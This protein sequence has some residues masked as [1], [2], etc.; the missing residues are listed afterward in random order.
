MKINV[1]YISCLFDES[2]WIQFQ[3]HN[4]TVKSILISLF[5]QY[6]QIRK[7][8]LNIMIRVN[9]K[10][11]HPS[12]WRNKL[13]DGDEVLI[14]QEVGEIGFL[15]V[16]LTAVGFS[17][18]TAA[19]ISTV[20]GVVLTVVS[21][22]YTIYSYCT[23][24]KPSHSG[25]AGLNNSPT[26]GWDGLQMQV[27]QG[28]PVPIVY[29]EH[30]VGGN[31]IDCYISS[32]SDKNYLNM[33]IAL[34]EG[35]IEGIMKEDLSGTCSVLPRSAEGLIT[36]TGIPVADDN[37]TIGGRVLTWMGGTY[38]P[39]GTIFV[40][41]TTLECVMNAID[42]INRDIGNLVVADKWTGNA[43]R[44]TAV[45]PGVAGNTIT[46]TESSA[47]TSMSGSGFLAGGINGDM[48]YVLIN[49]NLLSNYRSV[50]YD[51][52]TGTQ[53]Q[54]AIAGFGNVHQTYSTSGVL[55]GFVPYTYT[56]VDSDVEAIEVRVRV[57]AMYVQYRGDYY[58]RTL[59]FIVEHKLTSSGTWIVDGK[60]TITNS[61]LSPIRRYYKIDNLTAGRY[62][63]RLTEYQWDG[64]VTNDSTIVGRIYL[65]NVIE[66]KRDSLAYPH[67][68]LLALKIM[69]T[70]QLSGG[71]PNVL[72]RIRGIKVY[73]LSTTATAWTKNP[74][75]NI[76]NLMVNTRYGV[77]NYITQSN[78]NV[79]QFILMAAYC[80]TVVDAESRFELDIVIDSFNPAFDT[81]NQICGSFRATP[82][83]NK[84]AIQLLIDKAETPSYIFNM[85]SIIEGS[86][87]HTFTSEKS[88]ANSIIVDFAD[89]AKR[90]QKETVEITDSAVITGGTPRRTRNM[91][92]IGASRQSQVY[93]EARYHL[94]AVKYQDEQI[95]FR[96]A[97]D[98]IHVLPGDVVK[99]QHDTFEW[100]IGGRVVTATAVSITVDQSITIVGGHTYTLTCKLSNDTLESK[101]LTNAAGVHTVL[102]VAGPGFTSAPPAFGIYVVGETG[103]DVKT[104]RIMSL[105]KTPN[106]EIEVT[107]TEYSASVYSD[108]AI[109]VATPY[110][111]PSVDNPPPPDIIPGLMV[112]PECTG[113][114][115][116][117]ATDAM[118]I[119]ISFTIPSSLTNWSYGE[120]QVSSNLGVTY[121]T[122]TTFNQQK[123]YT[124]RDV[125][126]GATYWVKIL[127]F[128]N[129]G[130]VGTSPPTSSIVIAGSV[131]TPAVPTGLALT[132]GISK[133]A[134]ATDYSWVY[135]NWNDNVETNF[136][137]YEYRIKETGGYYT[138]GFV[139]SSDILFT[140]IRS[141]ILYYVGV[142]A[143]N[144]Y[145]TSSAFCT[146]V[147]VTSA[148]DTTAPAVPTALAASSTFK[149]IVLTWTNPADS[150]LDYINIY[151]GT[152]AVRGGATLVAQVNGTSYVDN[153]GSYGLTRYYWISAVDTSGNISTETG[154]V[155]ATTAMIATS[156]IDSFAID[157]SKIFTK[158]PIITG[159]SWTN[160]SPVAGSI[161]WGAHTLIYN[162]VSYTIAANNTS[163][164]YIYWIYGN[165]FYTSSNTHPAAI[166]TDNDFIIAVNNSGVHDLAWNSIANEVIGSV[167]IQNAAIKTALI[168]DLQV[169]TIKIANNAVSNRGEAR[170]S[171]E[172]N[173][174]S[175]TYVD[176]L[177]L[178]L[179]TNGGSV[180]ISARTKVL[181]AQN[182]T[183]YLQL[184]RDSTVIDGPVA[185]TYYIANAP[186]GFIPLM[187][188]DSPS[189]GTY[190]YKLQARVGTSQ[191]VMLYHTCIIATEYLK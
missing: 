126:A 44:V 51:Y 155:N 152:T 50:S 102:T 138:Y 47:L 173:V 40:G 123:S 105:S 98:A 89:K 29:G 158:I 28:I 134:D 190:T 73:N 57:P 62:N 54:T 32:Y 68:A 16:I 88:K 34:S 140:N 22:A 166:L 145:G 77:G 110:I 167:Y 116:T 144:D 60:M 10:K 185:T 63:V 147:S 53:S 181:S 182:H 100:G 131:V 127:S 136:A 118:G 162:G 135:A 130:V 45:D 37:M 171:D 78:V 25:G 14:I 150:D 115:L 117:N 12:K 21:L 129:N 23:S 187:D 151:R 157:A 184:V 93:R 1:R 18:T 20:V 161:A 61:S 35:E 82:I 108:A 65:D 174:T 169:T 103:V 159:D 26:Y 4:E 42:A 164:K 81:I 112:P 17:A 84:D 137:N 146:D 27:R 64:Q 79:D 97:I 168:D 31:L 154:P 71:I 183:C 99:F 2:T 15:T 36:F 7:D 104:F 132:T 106:N 58:P 96:G 142:R 179:T 121:S 178:N 75:Y 125:I 148:K 149:T 141:N 163:L 59:C 94:Y 114:T 9:G 122:V 67:T 74:I 165:S 170:Y 52:R 175:T 83:W 172:Y 189:A 92:L 90:F 76:N 11:L 143:I 124:Y 128:S 95:S 6:P 69:A 48:P 33:L 133:N 113:L 153:L 119:V 107:A 70:E 30:L 49:D 39:P 191:S 8:S 188:I 186:A 24:S 5:Q 91:S 41:A 160:N 180:H 13:N 156:D 109:I 101:T 56:T 85:G 177:T 43:I 46:F 66:I 139:T 176:V 120:I 87:S 38:L 19:T 111:P 86:F 3:S 72:T 55:L 80:D